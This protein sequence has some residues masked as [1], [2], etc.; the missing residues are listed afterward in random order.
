MESRVESASD[1]EWRRFREVPSAAAD[2][3]AVDDDEDADAAAAAV[4][5]DTI[6][7]LERA[8]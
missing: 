2:D 3:E 4:G 7:E 5:G 6:V 1:V 8:L